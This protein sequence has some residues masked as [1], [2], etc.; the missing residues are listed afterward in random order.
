LSGIN[1]ITGWPDNRVNQK[2]S[3]YY[4][5]VASNP[6]QADTPGLFT[7]I[8]SVDYEP[9]PSG[10]TNTPQSSTGGNTTEVELDLSG[11]SGVNA[12]Q[13]RLASGTVADASPNLETVWREFDVFGSQTVAAPEPSSL[14]ALGGLATMGLF[15]FAR[16]RKAPSG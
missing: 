12:I 16:R 2:Y 6:G 10:P 14:L 8:Q 5:T 7:L 9:D 13:F 1:T 15:L 11:I 4:S 3:V